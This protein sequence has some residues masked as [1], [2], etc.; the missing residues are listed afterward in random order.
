M[1]IFADL[2]DS[3]MQPTTH[4]SHSKLVM[5]NSISFVD[6]AC[7]VLLSGVLDLG[8]PTSVVLDL[9]TVEILERIFL[10]IF[11]VLANTWIGFRRYYCNGNLLRNLFN[12][13]CRRDC[14]DRLVEILDW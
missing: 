8:E 4:V 12:H 1:N 7:K 2:I 5:H 13:G 11:R 14:R 3:W 9:V 10:N 6:L